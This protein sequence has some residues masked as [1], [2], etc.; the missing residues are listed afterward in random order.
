[1][2]KYNIFLFLTIPIRL[3]YALLGFPML[4]NGYIFSLLLAWTTRCVYSVYTYNYWIDYVKKNKELGEMPA[5]GKTWFAIFFWLGLGVMYTQYNENDK[6]FSA[7]ITFL[8]LA[9]GEK[10]F[11]GFNFG[12]LPGTLF[13]HISI[14][15]K[16]AF[17]A[18]I[19]S[20]NY[21]KLTHNFILSPIVIS[22]EAIIYYNLKRQEPSS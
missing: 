10:S 6:L 17:F 15:I 8:F 4:E 13:K 2:S 7:Y 21:Y 12:F 22:Y 14:F 1:M 9:F 18:Y 11:G 20:Q 3:V 5:L 16:I 19:D